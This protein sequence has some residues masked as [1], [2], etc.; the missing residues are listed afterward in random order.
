MIFIPCRRLRK[1]PKNC[2]KYIFGCD[3]LAFSITNV[4]NQKDLITIYLALC[5]PQEH[6]DVFISQ[7][8]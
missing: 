3:L 5:V 8:C 7:Q 1:N 2:K 4:L 6:K